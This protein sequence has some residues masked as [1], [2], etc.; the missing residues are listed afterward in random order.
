[1]TIGFDVVN[2]VVDLVV[3]VVVGAVVIL[4][5]VVTEDGL[6]VELKKG[7]RLVVEVCAC[8]EPEDTKIS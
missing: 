6:L 7:R 8:V 4:T 5:V 1:M 2:L 3:V